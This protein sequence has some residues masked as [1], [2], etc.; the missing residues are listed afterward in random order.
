MRCRQKSNTPSLKCSYTCINRSRF[1]IR[2]KK[3]LLEPC[4]DFRD[5]ITPASEIHVCHLACIA[6]D[7]LACFWCEL[8]SFSRYWLRSCLPSL[9]YNRNRLHSVCWRIYCQGA[10]K[11][12][13][14]MLRPP[15]KSAI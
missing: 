1:Q 4:L 8:L 14:L 12:I 7:R 11:C 13:S 3:L 9:K 2:A 15:H 5:K 10:F 6:I